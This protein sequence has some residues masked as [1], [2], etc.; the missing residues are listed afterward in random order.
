MKIAKI[1]VFNFDLTYIHGT[2]T[3]SG[4]RD[5]T[6]LPSTIVRVTSDSGHEGWGE[7]CPLGSAYLPQHASGARAALELLAPALIGLDPT[8]ISGVYDAMDAVL[9]GHSYAKSP[10]DVA[11]WDLTGK[12]WGASVAE[13][14][15][16]V[17]QERFPLY[18]AVP[19]GSPE[20]MVSYVLARREEGIHRFQLK[21]G[22]DPTLDGIRAKHI[23]DATGPEDLIVGDANCGW[24]VNDAIIAARAM[25]N[26]PRFYFE[27]PCPTM[28]E[29]IEVRKHT[30]L[31]MVY[32]EVVNDPATLIRAVRE[33]GAGAFNLK[34]SKVGGLTKAK[35]MRDLGQELGLQITV[36]DTWGGDVVSAAS[37]HLAASTKER[38][39]LSV[40]F[41]NDWTNEHV[42]GYQPRSKNGFGSAPS[43]PG[44][45][46]EID[47]GALGQPLYSF[48]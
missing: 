19:L 6:S 34:V 38:A 8:N 36:E 42:A 16:G 14:L 11:C 7:V 4:G 23:I 21:I 48:C 1:D 2:Y 32:D 40:S 3:M 43:A 45:G 9:M 46:I 12:A 25:E 15:G 13:M 24:R 22:G 41:M 30:T 35:L 18:F 17:R 28:E 37:A 26:L 29:C 20:E 5:I 10:I 27:Q 31:P 39:L 47:A 33:G 44:L